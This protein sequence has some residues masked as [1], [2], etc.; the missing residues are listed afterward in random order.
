M[1]LRMKDFN[2]MV[3]P[4][5]IQIFTEGSTKG[6]YWGDDLKEEK[7][8]QFAD[9]IIGALVTKRGWGIWGM[10]IPQPNAYYNLAKLK[11]CAS[12]CPDLGKSWKFLIRN[13]S[14]G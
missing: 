13:I 8:W 7:L 4:W 10:L 2:I 6:I 5:K 11:L 3:V 1:G 14:Q 9:L 12:K